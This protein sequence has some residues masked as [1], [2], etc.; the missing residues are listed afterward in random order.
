MLKV[1]PP[2]KVFEHIYKSKYWGE[3]ESVSGGGSTLQQTAEVRKILPELFKKYNVNSFLDLPC[4]DFYWMTK[5]DLSGVEYIGAD[6]VKDIIRKNQIKYPAK[7]LK[8]EVIDLLNDNLPAVD[9][10]M[11]RDCFI[12]LSDENIFKGLENIKRSKIKYLLTTSY[13]DRVANT[14]ILTGQWRPLNLLIAPF[15]LNYKEIISEK[16]TEANGIYPDK[17]LLLIDLETWRN[18]T[19]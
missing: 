14:D 17:S 1:K 7:K 8:F 16:C 4:G 5:V 10:M 18:N 19:A 11:C 15:N 13:I 2:E 3:D 9:L 6:I 12:H